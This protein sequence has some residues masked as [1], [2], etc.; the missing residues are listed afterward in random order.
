MCNPINL[1]PSYHLY[2]EGNSSHYHQHIFRITSC[3]WKLT[4]LQRF[5]KKILSI[6]TYLRRS[7][8]H[9]FEVLKL[10]QQERILVF[11]IL[12][13]LMDEEFQ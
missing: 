8:S 11:L 9:K 4:P 7:N 12:D 1:K 10:G 3:V 6:Q 2:V 5:A 13:D